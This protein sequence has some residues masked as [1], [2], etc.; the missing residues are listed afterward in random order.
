MSGT[1][2]PHQ[3]FWAGDVLP[4]IYCSCFQVLLVLGAFGLRLQP[5]WIQVRWLTR[6]LQNIPHC[7]K[8]RSWA[9]HS[10][11]D[12]LTHP[13]C[14]GFRSW[15]V[16]SLPPYSSLPIIIVQVD[17]FVSETHQW[18]PSR[19]KPSLV[20][21]SSDCWPWRHLEGALKSGKRS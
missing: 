21:S 16:P 6:T 14:L 7:L 20:K 9:R 5:S 19:G 4:G 15:A 10:L 13:W 17:L 8:R 3:M 1:R 2:R 18:F 11:D 12:G